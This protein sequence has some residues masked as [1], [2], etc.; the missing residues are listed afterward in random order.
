MKPMSGK[1][2]APRIAV[3]LL[4]GVTEIEF[5]VNG[6]FESDEGRQF[7]SGSYLAQVPP[8]SPGQFI[9][10]SE[11]GETI[12]TGPQL[13]LRPTISTNTFRIK[14]VVIGIGFH[15]EQREEQAF[16][17]ELEV[18]VTKALQLLMINRTSVEVY[19]TSVI[20]SEMSDTAHPEL[21]KAH[22]VI[23]RS[24][25]LAQLSPW[26]VNRQES[27]SG[28]QQI[29]AQTIIRWYDRENHD[30][31]DVCA[32]DHCQRYQ[33]VTKAA[34]ASALEATGKT[35]GEVLMFGGEICDARYSKSCGGMIESYPAA[36]EDVEIAYLTAHYDGEVWPEEYREPLT[37]EANAE[38]WILGDPPSFCS[39]PGDEVLAKILPGFDQKTGDYYRWVRRLEQGELIDLLKRKLNLEIGRVLAI[40]PLERGA[41]GRIIR[42]RLIG[43]QATVTI[44]K[45][46]EIRRALS[47]SHLYS[48]AFVVR[49]EVGGDHV[50]GAFTLHGAGWGHGVGLCQIGAAVMA[51]K[52]FDYAQILRHYFPGVRLE[53]AY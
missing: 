18:R 16:T 23:S 45:E 7:T 10:I 41:S 2:E 48:S 4:S 38:S 1:I 30:D 14:N 21:L 36:W 35:A 12:Y 44:G 28:A 13:R 50:P 9:V 20:S 31:F 49:P 26:K 25:L 42:L 33:G 27:T 6:I 24:W 17:G 29:D 11:A 52:G 46:L 40:E 51:E 32:D 5:S 22:A 3:G 37:T 8:S 47:S 43:E 34:T 19:L 53:R 15:W 39:P